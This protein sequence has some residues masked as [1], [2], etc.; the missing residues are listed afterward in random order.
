[1]LGDYFVR[2]HQ[3]NIVFKPSKL[4]FFIEKYEY[5]LKYIKTNFK[6]C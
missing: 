4:C 2:V 5:L 6:I 1:M 3:I